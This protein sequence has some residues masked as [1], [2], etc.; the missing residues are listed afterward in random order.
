M[1]NS[2][3]LY[4]TLTREKKEIL[5]LNGKTLGYYCCGPTVY[6]AAHIGNFRTF[7]VQDFF[8]RIAELAGLKTNHVRN[9]TDVDDKTIRDSQ[10][11]GKSLDEFTKHWTSIFH[12]DCAKL[13]LLTPHTEPGAVE[14]IPHQ[15]EII[16]TLVHKGLAYQAEDGSVYYRVSAFAQYGR[17]SRLNEREITT[18]SDTANALA[19]EYERDSLAD[20]ALWKARKPEDGDNFWQSPWGEGRPGWHIE[21]SAMSKCYLGDSFDVHSGGV[22]L[23]FPHH[24]NEI[25]QSEGASGKTFSASWFHIT[26]LLVDGAKM[27]K[28]KGNLYT[29]AQLEERGYSGGDL[30]YALLMGHYR[31]PLNFTFESLDNAKNARKRIG[32]L[33]AAL[34]E[35]A[36]LEILPTHSELCSL[37]EISENFQAVWS[38]LLDDL[39]SPEALGHLFTAIKPL[40]AQIF[41]IKD[42]FTKEDINK[43]LMSLCFILSGMGIEPSMPEEIKIPEQVHELARKRVKARKAKNWGEADTLRDALKDA[44]WTVKDVPDGYELEPI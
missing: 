16:E 30:R 10:A 32:K 38:S 43:E 22:D 42:K 18:S 23:I 36:E 26:H 13:N 8:R 7:V 39:N 31:K 34:Q 17:L 35:A 3:L 21:C 19:D 33:I 44:G 37:E 24:E 20:F 4:D 40:E 28:S 29:L 1:K 25:A 11:S 2:V 12:K 6:A 41:K 14:H 9:I 27:S 5:P 15:I